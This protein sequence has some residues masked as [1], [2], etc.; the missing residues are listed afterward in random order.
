MRKSLFLI[1]LVPV[2]CMAQIYET[3]NIKVMNYVCHVHSNYTVRMYKQG[4]AGVWNGSAW[5]D[6]AWVGTEGFIYK[7][8]VG[9]KLIP[10]RQWYENG[11]FLSSHDS[12]AVNGIQAELEAWL[13]S[14]QPGRGSLT[15]QIPD[16][17]AGVLLGTIAQST[18]LNPVAALAENKANCEWLMNEI[19]KDPYNTQVLDLFSWPEGE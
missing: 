4:P 7:E 10:V 2:V 12:I 18:S 3:E 9:A 17:S 15:Y 8:K 16:D 1:L 6:T 5:V 11:Q 19:L 14:Q 13:N